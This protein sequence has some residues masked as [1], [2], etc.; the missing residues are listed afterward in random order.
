MGVTGAFMA[1]VPGLAA[2]AVR[3]AA[4]GRSEP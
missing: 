2:A 4:G 1:A 3:L